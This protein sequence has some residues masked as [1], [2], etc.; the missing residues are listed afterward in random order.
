MRLPGW[1]N[2]EPYSVFSI[3]QVLLINLMIIKKR[4]FIN[5]GTAMKYRGW[6]SVFVVPGLISRQKP[7]SICGASLN[8]F[9]QK[10]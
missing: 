1:L 3:Y 7:R 4:L 8:L 5:K 2:I 6:S 10:K 9:G